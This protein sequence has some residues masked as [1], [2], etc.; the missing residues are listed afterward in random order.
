MACEA[1]ISALNASLADEANWRD[2]DRM[3]RLQGDLVAKRAALA[4][5]EAEW[6]AHGS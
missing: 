5:L 6:A 2:G 4:A 3:R 1:A